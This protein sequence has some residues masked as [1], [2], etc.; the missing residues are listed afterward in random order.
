VASKKGYFSSRSESIQKDVEHVFAI[1]K[2]RWRI[3]D[4][5]IHFKDMQKVAR[6]F[7]VSCNLHNIMLS[8]MESRDSDVRVGRGAPLPGDDIWLHGDD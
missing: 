6:V 5:G 3:L 1:V 2:K 4:Y 8:K 7:T